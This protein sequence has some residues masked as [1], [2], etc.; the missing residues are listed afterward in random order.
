MKKKIYYLIYSLLLVFVS[1]VFVGCGTTPTPST[2]GAG[3]GS[4]NPSEGTGSGGGSAGSE[5]T[6]ST[7]YD[8]KILSFLSE[9]GAPSG[10]H[11]ATLLALPDGKTAVIDLYI[12]TL[13]DQTQFDYDFFYLVNGQTNSDG[14]FVIDYFIS[15]NI[16]DTYLPYGFTE[17][18]EI[19]NF[20]RPNIELDLD[21]WFKAV[22]TDSS[23]L[24]P[25]LNTDLYLEDIKAIPDSYLTGDYQAFYKDAQE[26]IPNP[27]TQQERS[28]DLYCY[29]YNYPQT[30]LLTLAELAR[31]NVNVI[32]STSDTIISNT[33]N[34]NGKT[35]NYSIDFFVPEP[36]FTPIASDLYPML[37]YQQINHSQGVWGFPDDPEY[38][39]ATV[40]YDQYAEYRSILSISYNGYDTLYLNEPTYYIWDSLVKAHDPSIKYEFMVASYYHKD[41]HPSYKFAWA[42]VFEEYHNKGIYIGS[43][44]FDP[45]KIDENY[46]FLRTNSMD[47]YFQFTSTTSNKI[48]KYLYRYEYAPD[49]MVIKR[50]NT[51]LAQ[52]KSRGDR[53]TQV[54]N[55]QRD[56]TCN[57][58][59]ITGVNDIYYIQP[60]IDG[61]YI[62]I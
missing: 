6:V 29:Y 41:T 39:I 48:S 42:R 32:C 9:K 30:Y 52:F 1:F 50:E 54:I 31:N 24:D 22:A 35:Y 61:V 33:F 36:R 12:E 55:I 25:F 20:Y 44:L 23:L 38:Y 37:V 46:F 27:T 34:N 7:V 10:H 43:L 15:T 59:T 11:H 8:M 2:P 19:K 26:M 28:P 16:N 62:E 47:L 21:L 57:I 18:Y 60:S 58:N 3:G 40:S 53:T 49:Q 51:L 5:T 14:K 17:M 56:G 13:S 45:A 4:S